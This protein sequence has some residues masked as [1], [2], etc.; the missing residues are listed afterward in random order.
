MNNMYIQKRQNTLN[1]ILSAI[2]SVLEENRIVTKKE[3]MELTNLSSGTFSKDY[4]K[5]LL[6]KNNV[7]QYRCI[8]RSQEY[9]EE[10]SLLYQLESA[11][12][13]NEQL[14]SKKQDLEMKIELQIKNTKK[15][16][17]EYSTLIISYELLSGKYQQLLE[18]L[19]A[20]DS[21]NIHGLSII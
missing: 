15:I 1:L 6:K 8:N 12:K 19:D 17:D 13:E 16:K 3:L 18:Y 4:V 21:S 10:K 20:I 9:I 5:A 14:Y 2:N 11:L 7:C